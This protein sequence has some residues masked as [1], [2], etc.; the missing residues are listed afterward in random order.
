MRVGLVFVEWE[1]RVLGVGCLEGVK[2]VGGVMEDLIFIYYFVYVLHAFSFPISVLCFGFD[3]GF[4]DC[5]NI[6][7]LI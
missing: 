5:L 4:L 6:Q 2:G 7:Y 1:V 3:F